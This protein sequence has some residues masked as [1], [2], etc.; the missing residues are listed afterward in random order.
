[1]LGGYLPFLLDGAV[2]S[3]SV[4]LLSFFGAIILGLGG[5]AAK[6]SRHSQVLRAGAAVY[7]TVVR[8]VPEL[9]LILLIYYGFPI[10]LQDALR[11]VGFQ[12]ARLDFEPFVAGVFTLSLIYGAFATE[13]F[14]G[15]YQSLNVGQIEAAKAIG[16]TRLSIVWRITLPQMA[17]LCIAGMSN[18]WM[19]LVKATALMSAIQLDELMRKADLAAGATRRPFDMIM[20]AAVIYLLITAVSMLAQRGLERRVH[21]KRPKIHVA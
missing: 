3:I 18:I 7:T 12:D 14:R 13:V 4:A 2:V 16:M 19:V 15:A 10:L 6:L 11:G 17:P 8:G 9:V 21:D 1:M 5:A 20:T